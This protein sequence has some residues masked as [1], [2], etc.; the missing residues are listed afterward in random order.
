MYKKKLCYLPRVFAKRLLSSVLLNG[1]PDGQDLIASARRPDQ[2]YMYLFIS[3]YTLISHFQWG[4]LLLDYSMFYRCVYKP[5]EIRFLAQL[6]VMIKNTIYIIYEFA[7]SRGSVYY[8]S[9]GQSM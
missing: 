8:R 2:E 1:F 6:I 3:H 4:D 5:F 9:Y 7:Y